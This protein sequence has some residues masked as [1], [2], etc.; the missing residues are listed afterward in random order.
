MALE[1][2]NISKSFGTNN[3]LSNIS[4]SIK[5]GEFFVL[6]GPSGCGKTT[7]LR[8]IAGLESANEGDVCYENTNITNHSP[9]DRDFSMVFQYFALY[10]TMKVFDNIAYP[11][12]LKAKPKQDIYNNVIK[13]AKRLHIE[14]LLDRYPKK[15]SG[16]EI[17]RVSLAKALIR[18]PK[19]FLLDE[20][21]S[22]LDTKLR[23][24]MRDVLRDLHNDFG[25]T[26][27]MVTH[28]QEEAL[29]L[30]T[31]IAIINGGQ[32]QQVGT[33]D[34]IYDRPEN[35]F[36][37]SF[38]GNHPINFFNAKVISSNKILLVKQKKEIRIQNID[39]TLNTNKSNK[40]EIVIGIRPEDIQ[41][42]NRH[43]KDESFEIT[44]KSIE[45]FGSYNLLKVKFEDCDDV[46]LLNENRNSNNKRCINDKINITFN[47][48]HVFDSITKKRIDNGL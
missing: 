15:L 11:L 39:S 16:G 43:H 4:I 47:N 6:L 10:P 28:D 45:S 3:V 1:L 29:S 2:R 8:I 41:I 7:L 42:V 5:N 12:K 34:D 14:N 13:M 27:I 22:N 20:P 31:K 36:T 48:F 30:G 9:K 46:L 40:N 33:P 17:Q 37:A 26:N 21:L 35:I 19:L 44:I 18:S 25:I 24:S 23:I 32:I 38:I